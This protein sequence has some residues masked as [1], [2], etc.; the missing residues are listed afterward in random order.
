MHERDISAN[1]TKAVV[2]S[3]DGEFADLP[4]LAFINAEDDQ[5]SLWNRVFFS[6]RMESAQCGPRSTPNECICSY[7]EGISFVSQ[8]KQEGQQAST[9]ECALYLS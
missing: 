8:M 2:E 3:V 1:T 4:D 6:S 7:P 9:R 5:P